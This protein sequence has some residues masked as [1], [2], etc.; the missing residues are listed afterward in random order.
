MNRKRP[1]RASGPGAGEPVEPGDTRDRIFGLPWNNLYVTIPVFAALVVGV[2][3]L[4]NDFAFDDLALIVQNG[5]IKELRNIPYF[6]TSGSW[7]ISQENIWRSDA[8][9]RP[10]FLSLLAINHAIFGETPWGWHLVSLL[11]HMAVTILVFLVCREVSGRDWLSFVTAT[12]F[13]VHPVHSE[14]VAWAS[15]ASVLLMSLFS[16]SAFYLHLLYRKTGRARLLALALVSALLAVLS[17]E[18]AVVLPALIAYWEFAH[19][20]EPSNRKR[21]ISGLRFAGLFAVPVLLYLLQRHL[22]VGSQ[23]FASAASFV[24]SGLLTTPIAL[25]KYLW[26]MVVPTGYSIQHFTEPVPSAASLAFV[27]P[28]LLAAALGAAVYFS[29]SRVLRFAAAWFIIWLAPALLSW[30]LLDPVYFVQE[31]YAYL[32]SMGFCLAAAR[33]IEWLAGRSLMGVSGKFAA[34]ALAAVTAIALGAIHV[35]QNRVWRNTVTLYENSVHVAP[36]SPWARSALS[37]AHFN[38]GDTKAAEYQSGMAIEIDPLFLDG[39]M[40]LSHFAQS[41][42]DYNLAVNYLERAKPVAASLSP[43]AQ[44]RVF[45]ALGAIHE[46]RR[47]Y[48]K[49]EENYRLAVEAVPSRSGANWYALGDF[50]Y[51]RGRYEEAREMFELVIPMISD[52]FAPIHLKLGRIYDRLGQT[53]Q[54]RV[55]YE[56]YL[57]LAPNAEDYSDVA[58]RLSQL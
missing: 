23:A 42:G 29:R 57:E 37:A 40:N 16:L 54:A 52:G 34:A 47:D 7:A 6:F 4:R 46:A 55:A 30:R 36:R 35:D 48:R 1:T 32:A 50:Y 49:A 45:R 12:L 33:G 2:N 11:L 58:R 27:G 18:T 3:T 25:A 56:K 9:F 31:R 53:D 17:K 51:N 41:V 38:K 22:S 26:L 39:Y 14:A 5:A 13:A 43:A 21:L 20:N 44:A 19:A 8:Y 24:G 28:L 10:I 15:G